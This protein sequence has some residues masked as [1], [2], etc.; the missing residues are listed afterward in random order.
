MWI[1]FKPPSKPMDSVLLAVH[2]E[3]FVELVLNQID[4]SFRVALY[5]PFDS[6]QS[7][8][9][10]VRYTIGIFHTYNEG[11]DFALDILQSLKNGEPFFETQNP[12]LSDADDKKDTPQ[13]TGYL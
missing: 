7:V 10:E 11:L 3:T 1:I 4:K 6:H 9:S 5:K 12:F 13:R 8:R 2:A